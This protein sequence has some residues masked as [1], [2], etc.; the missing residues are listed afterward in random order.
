MTSAEL[1]NRR[2]EE[3]FA[4]SAGI[5]NRHDIIINIIPSLKFY[6]Q[7]I[8]RDDNIMH[9]KIWIMSCFNNGPWQPRGQYFCISWLEMPLCCPG[10]KIFQ[11]GS[12]KRPI[13]FFPI[14]STLHV[15]LHR[16]L[17]PGH[18]WGHVIAF[19]PQGQFSATT[20]GL[21]GVYRL[22][23]PLSDSG[24]SVSWAILKNQYLLITNRA[25]RKKNYH[26]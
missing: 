12:S 1:K 5:L 23:N 11:I 18:P 9:G 14:N 8:D 25:R 24:V 19:L 10:W 4:S 6:C 20:G 16:S 22:K 2:G 15:S 26:C 17:S 3:Q 13:Q 7:I 21:V